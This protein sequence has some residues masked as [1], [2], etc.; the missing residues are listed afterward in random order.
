MYIENK[1]FN[2]EK[3]KK[4]TFIILV[5]SK[6][7]SFGIHNV[8]FNMLKINIQIKNTDIL[9]IKL[10]LFFLIILRKFLNFN[11]L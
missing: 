7:F 4:K 1:Y 2:L 11:L 5:K 9:H 6:N 8:Y 10:S 3:L